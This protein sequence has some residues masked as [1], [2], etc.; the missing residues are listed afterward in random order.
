[1]LKV[2]DPTT[3]V[4]EMAADWA[5]ADALLGGTTS[6]RA[7]GKKYL[8]K[9]EG[10]SE[11]GYETRLSVATLLPAFSRTVSVMASKPSVT[12]IVKEFAPTVPS[13]FL[14]AKHFWPPKP[15]LPTY[16]PLL[17]A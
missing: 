13:Y 6:M 1:M 4:N 10:E 11:A 15:A 5:M 12:S 8:P 9:M 16:L 7:A 14:Q 2:N 3:E 17:A